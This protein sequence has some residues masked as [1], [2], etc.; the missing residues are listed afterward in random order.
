MSSDINAPATSRNLV[1]ISG[2]GYRES[3]QLRQAHEADSIKLIEMGLGRTGLTLSHLNDPRLK[4]LGTGHC[5]QV[6][7]AVIVSCLAEQR[8]AFVPVAQ[9]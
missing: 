3:I 7:A 2:S 8:V 6:Q 9:L 1:R 4:R 5:T